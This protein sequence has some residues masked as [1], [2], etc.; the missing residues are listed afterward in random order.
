MNLLSD[1]S[2]ELAVAIL[3]NKERA[4]NISSQQGADLIEKV[5][6]IL[7]P[8]ADAEKGRNIASKSIISKNSEAKATNH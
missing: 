5:Y 7:E 3:V 1:I 4:K 8:V 2:S 6:E